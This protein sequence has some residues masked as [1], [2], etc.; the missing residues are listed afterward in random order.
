MEDNRIIECIERAHYI[1]S[2]LMAVKP[3][4]VSYTHLDVYKR[5][6]MGRSS[7]IRT[8]FLSKRFLTTS[9]F[10]LLESFMG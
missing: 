9:F 4:A 1:L 7:N 8:D 3:G 2:N 6:E 5:Q 10:W